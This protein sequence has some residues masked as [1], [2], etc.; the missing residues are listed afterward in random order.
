MRR[1]FRLMLASV[2]LVALLPG[3]ANAQGPMIPINLNCEEPIG[4]VT[5]EANPVFLWVPGH[6]TSNEG[7]VTHI[8]TGIFGFE[9]GQTNNAPGIDTVICTI[10]GG[11]LDGEPV[12]GFFVP[13]GP[14]G[15]PR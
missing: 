14:G 7:L 8:V 9:K 11:P 4:D 13:G 3:P 5:V 6:V 15:P 1:L 12:E 2:F 10:V